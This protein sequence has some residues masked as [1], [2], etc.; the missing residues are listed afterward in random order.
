M[1][2]QEP[3][4][5]VGHGELATSQVVLVLSVTG[6]IFC[7]AL[8]IANVVD[9][10]TPDVQAF[11]VRCEWIAVSAAI[12]AIIC[13]LLQLRQKSTTRKA[14][15]H[16]PG[17]LQIRGVV[18]GC[19]GGIIVVG[20]IF[21]WFGRGEDGVIFMVVGVFMLPFILVLKGH[22]FHWRW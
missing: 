6:A 10:N 17:V 2:D 9:P 8:A 7:T 15:T 3:G 5:S 12:L 22:R 4:S 13:G 1:N 21:A 16:S 14:L 11:A 19:V 18:G 20:G